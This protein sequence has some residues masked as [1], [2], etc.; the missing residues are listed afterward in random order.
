MTNALSPPGIP[1]AGLFAPRQR[2]WGGGWAIT[3]GQRT[4]EHERLENRRGEPTR[5][6]SCCGASHAGPA[7]SSTD[8]AGT[9]TPR[10]QRAGRPERHGR[11]AHP[12][13]PRPSRPS[14]PR[15][16]QHERDQTDL[17]SDHR[18]DRRAGAGRPRRRPG[19]EHRHRPASLLDE[20][21]RR[22][23]ERL[24]IAL[25][26]PRS[27]PTRSTSGARSPDDC[28]RRAPGGRSVAVAAR[29]CP[30]SSTRRSALLAD[31]LRLL[32]GARRRAARPV[33]NVERPVGV[34]VVPA[35]QASDGWQLMPVL[36]L[37]TIRLIAELGGRLE[38]DLRSAS[39]RSAAARSCS[40][41]STS[42]RCT[43]AR[44]S[45]WTRRGSSR[46]S[47]LASC[48]SRSARACRATSATGGAASP[49][50][51]AP[52]RAPAARHGRARA[53]GADVPARGFG[54]RRL[55][56]A[57]REEQYAH[58]S[59][60]MDLGEAVQTAVD[61]GLPLLLSTEAAGELKDTVRV[62]G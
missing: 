43:P 48:R 40:S 56:S 46:R 35:L 14:P 18:A 44:G 17:G 22:A 34:F 8:R 57:P 47:S 2:S 7:R 30:T 9:R 55:G 61:A 1:A 26:D 50:A 24:P 45:A 32:A 10:L 58:P 54:Q 53:A 49:S 11:L 62:G 39:Y 3:A 16:R 19:L 4:L 28:A 5:P 21:L 13:R 37:D 41:G 25:E 31:R 15:P 51:A 23:H 38:R 27:G 59:A 12:R 6:G 36:A 29:S 52:T 20:R 33:G 42:I 60:V